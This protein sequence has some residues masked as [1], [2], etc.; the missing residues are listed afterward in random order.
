M[1]TK[2]KATAKK[3][4]PAKKKPVVSAKQKAARATFARKAK[5]AGALV[6]SG[7]APNMKA[8]FKKVK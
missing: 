6:S 5:K 8:A 2:K 7:K 4:T 1:A 3:K